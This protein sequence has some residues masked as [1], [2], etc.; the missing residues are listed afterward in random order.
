MGYRLD[1]YKNEVNRENNLYYGT[2]LIGYCDYHEEELLCVNYLCSIREDLTP[3]DFGYYYAPEINLTYGEFKRFIY[4]YFFDL[5][6]EE[7][8]YPSS[9]KVG[10][11]ISIS[12][13]IYNCIDYYY[14][15]IKDIFSKLCF[16]DHVI[17]RWC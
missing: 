8:H 5:T 15:V 3:E 12:G 2:K 9:N 7:L 1:I 4:L 17:V 10:D 11:V 13:H 6:H 16:L 14:N